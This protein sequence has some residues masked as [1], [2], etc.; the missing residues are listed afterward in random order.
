MATRSSQQPDPGLVRALWQAALPEPREPE[1]PADMAEYDR[2]WVP[3]DADAPC[4]P[5][6]LCWDFDG[7]GP[8]TGEFARI[9]AGLTAEVQE[10][11]PDPGWAIPGVSWDT[12]PVPAALPPVSPVLAGL[13]AAVEAVAALDPARLPGGQVLVDAEAL[14]GVLQQLRV[15]QLG[16][17]AQ[18]DSRD[19]HELRG[20]RTMTGWLERH[21][22]DAV[23]ADR[24]LSGRLADLPV[25]AEAV[26]T[27]RVSLAA[28]TQ[29]AKA[30]SKVGRYLDCP[31]GLVDGQPGE[32]LVGQILLNTLDLVGQ[33]RGGLA[34]DAPLLIQL[35]RQLLDLAGAGGS[36]LTRISGAFTLLGEHLGAGDTLN[37]ALAQQVDAVLPNLLEEQLSAAEAKRGLSLRPRPNGAW[38]VEGDLTPEVGERLILA[39]A[40][41]ARRDPGNPVDTAGRAEARARAVEQAGGDPFT[42]SPALSDLP[43]WEQDAV[44]DLRSQPGPGAPAHEQQAGDLADALHLDPAQAQQLAALVPRTPSRRLHDAL[45]RL[46]SRY[47]DAG[48][49]GLVDKVP[50]QL[51]AT[52]THAQIEHRP[53]ALPAK[54]TRTGRSLARSLLRRW[55]NDAQIT[56]LLLSEG[57]Q[58]L[59]VVHSGRTLTGRER[60]AL[61]TRWDHRCAGTD[62]CPPLPEPLRTLVPHHLKRYSSNGGQTSLGETI[63]CCTNL[64][65]DIHLGKKT[66]RLRDGRLINENG[67]LEDG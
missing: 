16:W 25:L 4:D 50:V 55:W 11:E 45:G 59:G 43:R 66:I 2:R 18:V 3:S 48:L 64:H 30:C 12:E 39:L 27:G 5:D 37:S 21:A 61:N 19:L 7:D 23:K 67:Y 57:W 63:P 65:N 54:S 1:L 47:L 20:L 38:R 53:G 56:T 41:E 33:A 58:P 22:P 62:C 42:D 14:Q 46:L 51:T 29:V 34:D 49:G 36:M 31:D 35:R 8:C 26:R 13:L 28:A 52:I 10:P 32:P 15:T 6:C 60:R 24:T 9:V 17:T 40:A 44:R